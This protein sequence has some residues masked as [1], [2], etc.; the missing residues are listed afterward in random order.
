MGLGIWKVK[1]IYREAAFPLYQITRK[2]VDHGEPWTFKGQAVHAKGV[3]MRAEGR[4][5]RDAARA[6]NEIEQAA[7]NR[8]YLERS[9]HGNP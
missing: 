9:S 8:A 4:A 6:R 7:L 1:T 2:G 5:V 3:A